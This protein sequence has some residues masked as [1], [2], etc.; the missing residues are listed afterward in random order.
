MQL[1]ALV[2]WKNTKWLCLIKYRPNDTIIIELPVT[3]KHHSRPLQQ[4]IGRKRWRRL[5]GNPVLS[6]VDG[7]EGLFK[8]FTAP[9]EWPHSL[10]LCFGRAALF[11]ALLFPF[12][13]HGQLHKRPKKDTR[14]SLIVF[15]IF[16]FCNKTNHIKSLFKA[17]DKT[18]DLSV[19]S[20]T[21]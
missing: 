2:W 7:S 5:R 12:T 20:E 3:E 8:R 11:Q 13:S 10:L 17:L 15:V 4:Q 6:I 9:I 1:P 18:K 16:S 19:I 21:H 14:E